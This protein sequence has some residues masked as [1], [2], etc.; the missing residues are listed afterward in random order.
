MEIAGIDGAQ[1]VASL[2]Q[3]EERP[4]LLLESRKEAASTAVGAIARVRTGVE[5]FRLAATRLSTVS[6]FDRYKT[7]V[8]QPDAVSAS[9]SGTAFNSSISFSVDQ[10][11]RA[12]GL[13]S[14]STVASDSI[15]ITNDSV[16]AVAAGTLGIGVNT[17][18]AGAGLDAGTVQFDV[19][20]SSAG[21]SS[22]GSSPL[23]LPTVISG[24]NNT[25]AVHVNGIAHNVTIAA[26]SYD[27]QGLMQAVQDALDASNAGATASLDS[28]GALA[29]T[30][31]RKSVV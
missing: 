15:P 6:S 20:Q 8:S 25:I 5:S 18:R 21:G 29:L 2:M 26:G 9:V 13:R 24:A 1:I 10:L 11:A 23:P 30:T 22:V 27:Q 14:L 19:I 17:V 3:I 31:D 12:H 7:S 28:T 16:I 4:L